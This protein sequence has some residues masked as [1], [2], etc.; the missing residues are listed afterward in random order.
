MKK[1]LIPTAVLSLTI[2]SLADC[3]AQCSNVYTPARRRPLLKQDTTKTIIIN[4]KKY[5]VFADTNRTSITKWDIVDTS[6][7]DGDWVLLSHNNPNKILLQITYKN[8][9]IDGKVICKQDDGILLEEWNYKNGKLDG[10]QKE[11]FEN[12]K[13]DKMQNYKDG[14][15]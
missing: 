2:F 11:Y 6:L 9:L 8:R 1:F 5:F 4:S 10:E 15:E 13:I 7:Y 3:F 12:G 14:L